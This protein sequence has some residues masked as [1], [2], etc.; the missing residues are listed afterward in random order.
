MYLSR[1]PYRHHHIS[2]GPIYTWALLY[3]IH[4]LA[5][6]I[7]IYIYIC[8]YIYI[9]IV[10]GTYT[11][12]R[13]LQWVHIHPSFV[14]ISVPTYCCLQSR[15]LCICITIRKKWYTFWDFHIHAG[16]DDKMQWKPCRFMC[17]GDVWTSM[18]LWVIDIKLHHI[19]F[20]ALV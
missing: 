1:E 2:H 12:Y 4:F 7:Y 9:Y 20:D 3:F 8:I 17:L 14:D 15:R 19:L 16:T 13:T 6:Y 18:N 5:V 11:P 10:P